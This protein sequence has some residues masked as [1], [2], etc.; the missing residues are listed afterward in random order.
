MALS[1]EGIPRL[2]LKSRTPSGLPSLPADSNYDASRASAHWLRTE[3]PARKSGHA[4]VL[5]P[6]H[7]PL[8]GTGNLST[9]IASRLPHEVKLSNI[10]DAT[11]AGRI[12]NGGALITAPDQPI[13]LDLHL[14]P[15]K[16]PLLGRRALWESESSPGANGSSAASD[17]SSANTASDLSSANTAAMSNSR[18]V[19]PVASTKPG[20]YAR[21]NARRAE[22][23][24]AEEALQQLQAELESCREML[25]DEQDRMEILTRRNERLTARCERLKQVKG[26]ASLASSVEGDATTVSA[27]P[28]TA[29]PQPASSSSKRDCSFLSYAYASHPISQQK[30]ASGE[31]EHSFPESAAPSA[32]ADTG[33]A[34]IKL[35]PG[36]GTVK[37]SSDMERVAAI[38]AAQ[39]DAE[40]TV[41]EL[42][43]RAPAALQITVDCDCHGQESWRPPKQAIAHDACPTKRVIKG[44]PGRS[45][46]MASFSGCKDISPKRIVPFV[47]ESYGFKHL[48]TSVPDKT[49][50]ARFLFCFEAQQVDGPKLVA[51]AW[52]LVTLPLGY[53]TVLSATAG[54]AD[55]QVIDLNPVLDYFDTSRIQERYVFKD[56]ED[57][58]AGDAAEDGEDWDDQDES[59]F[60]ADSF[61]GL[62][63]HDE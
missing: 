38:T 45:V 5:I 11:K 36:N 21:R 20:K 25:E 30:A 14:I 55:G 58:D 56:F 3:D 49:N 9:A 1:G 26:D 8:L 60:G 33:L 32:N 10:I 59:E 29:R 6:G 44:L 23:K 13:V 62:A 51:A 54:T 42:L 63:L 7:A 19:S 52:S 16:L 50:K 4:S 31:M 24:Q 28:T 37:C 27:G 41:L 2:A 34:E 12:S 40:C 22:S 15:R 43:T 57:S 53:A 17:L 35:S 18:P 46:A 48:R 39:D 61:A 47:L